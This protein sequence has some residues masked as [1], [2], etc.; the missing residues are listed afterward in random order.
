MN[1]DQAK[2]KK[3]IPE[4]ELE[5][6][7]FWRENNIFEKSVAHPAGLDTPHGEF[8]FYDGPPF[9]TGLPHHGH[10]LAGTIK[11]AVPRYKTMRGYS[12]RRV[13]GW[14]CHG[15]PIENLIEKEYGLKHK[16]D[17][18]TFGIGKFNAA[19]RDSVLRYEKEWKE[20][21]PRLGRFIDMEHPYSTMDTEY[22]ESIWWSF[23]ELYN[24]GLIYEGNK[25]MYVCPRCETSL[26]QSE[27]A[28]GYK[29]VTD[30]SV[31]VK[32]ELVDEPG[33][34]VLAWTTTPWTLP[35]NVA[36]A[37]NPEAS[38]A[39]FTLEG[40]TGT[41]IAAEELAPKIFKDKVF[42]KVSACKGTDLAQ[43]S[44]KPVFS[45][46]K[47]AA[48]DNK[49]NIWK[50]WAAEFVTLDTGTGVVHIAPAFGA[51]D[52]ELAKKHK[53]PIIK[54][55]KMDGS[56]TKEVSDFEGVY[57]KQKD[58]TQSTDIL[59]IKY[60]AHAGVLFSKEKLVHSYPHCWRCET[61][62]LNYATGSWFVDV[63]KIKDRLL[64]ENQ[65]VHWVPEHIKDGRFGKWLE[66]ARE[67][68]IS[69]SRY[70]G[71]PLPVWKC[72]NCAHVKVVGSLKELGEGKKANNTYT[73]VRH[74]GAESNKHRFLDSEGDPNNDLTE[75]GRHQA[76]KTGEALK[77]HGYD[78]IIASPLLRA[79]H[80]AEIIAKIIGVPTVTTDIR[81]REINL[82]VYSNKG[83]GSFDTFVSE[84]GD[85]VKDIDARIPGGETHREVLER[86][87]ALWAELERTYTGKKILLVTHAAPAWM[88]ATSLE[89][90]TKEEIA[91]HTNNL[92][93][94]FYLKNGGY[95]TVSPNVVPRNEKG[96]ID[97]HR[98]YIDDVLFSCEKCG[99]N[100]KRILD[101]LDCWYESGS[102]PYA[103]IHYPFENKKLFTN[104]FPA[105]WIAEG[106]DQ[107]RG[108]FYSLINLSVGLFDKAPYKAVTVNGLVLAG[109]GQKMS[110]SKKNFT[111]PMEV[112]SRFGADALRYTLLSSPVVRG[113]N[114]AL[115]DAD[116][117][118]TYKKIILRLENVFS[119]YELYKGGENK[120]DPFASPNV[121]DRWVLAR[122][123]QL[124]QM[125]TTGYESYQLDSAVRPID[126][127]VDDLSVW[128]LRRSR[129]RLKGDTG[130]EDRNFALATLRYVLLTL[131]KVMAPVMPFMAER[132]YQ[133]LQGTCASVHLESWPEMAQGDQ[134]VISKMQHTRE[135]VSSALQVRAKETI[136]VRQ[137]LAKLSVPQLEGLTEEYLDLII[138]EVNVKEVVED[139]TLTDVVLDT[140]VTPE[141]KK[142]GDFREVVRKIQDKRKEQGL[143]PKDRPALTLF[144]GD[145]KDFFASYEQELK[146]KCQL[147]EIMYTTTEEKLFIEKD[148][149]T[150]G[151]GLVL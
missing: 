88:L 82:G 99:K 132:L 83:E 79:K 149:F 138:D 108:W 124:V 92:G 49:E 151:F 21:V 51:D 35:G 86:T 109:D 147:R 58:D 33:T 39:R 111:D 38:Y 9:A 126:P 40:E 114:V 29:D 95:Y 120:Q 110:K 145:H 73:I 8:S 117:D 87:N 123:A 37:V 81:L 107:T 11:D 6:L 59:I 61:P 14:D 148:P 41:F 118:E 46:F 44:Y 36:L 131:S 74:G 91:E 96:A 119:F 125:I 5:T 128:Y 89:G 54:H 135:L 60:L 76:H 121:L 15:L 7:S 64:A 20:I 31:T 116:V 53:L 1:E 112:V 129:D 71:A 115:S 4:K 77:D 80:T 52:M 136:K 104:S 141:L 85:R 130:E 43:K 90:C 10:I 68:A 143:T 12:V 47:G 55:V 97:L 30:I 24:K 34:Y 140:L 32:F 50:I 17:I 65:K 42:T 67:W 13:W 26:A 144:V 2:H 84:Q 137:P 69:R 27:V 28:L 100:M 106:L 3:T 94:K 113:E 62:L 98:P 45:Y 101:V 25:I 22:T 139:T 16:K 63:P 72:E 127:F 75:T 23:K 150:F 103:Q 102:M 146:E 142:E 57:V 134:A 133:G 105:E 70:W 19:A 93:S 66:G 18:E 48:L 56:F 78:V 122:L